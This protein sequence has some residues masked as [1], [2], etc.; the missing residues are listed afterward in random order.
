MRRT[1]SHSPNTYASKIDAWLLVI[2]AAAGAIAVSGVIASWIENGALRGAQTMIIAIA[3]VGLVAWV[4]LQTDYTID[5]RELA[6]RSGPFRWRIPLS[7]ISQVAPATGFFR[8]ASGP[9]LSLDRL[10]VT[11]RNR[12]LLISPRDQQRFLSDLRARQ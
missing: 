11:Y 4:L 10:V 5:S 9:A 2:F 3:I 6:V 1:S 7:D 8:V 12:R